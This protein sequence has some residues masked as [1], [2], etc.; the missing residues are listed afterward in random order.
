MGLRPKPPACWR[1]P[2]PGTSV[3]C[4]RDHHASD[5]S[6]VRAIGLRGWFSHGP[7]TDRERATITMCPVGGPP[8]PP[9]AL[10]R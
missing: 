7:C 4:P 3:A 8:V 1:A 9:T 6:S 2:G 10:T 5:A